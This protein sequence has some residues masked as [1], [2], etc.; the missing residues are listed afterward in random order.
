MKHSS[1]T[2]LGLAFLT[3][4]LAPACSTSTRIGALIPKHINSELVKGEVSVAGY[5]RTSNLAAKSET[6]GE[7]KLAAGVGATALAG[8]AADLA[9]DAVK[10][11]LDREAKKYE[12]QSTARCILSLEDIGEAGYFVFARCT[13]RPGLKKKEN[14]E[15]DNIP[16]GTEAASIISSLR[17]NGTSQEDFMAVLG[18]DVGRLI[19][20]GKV[21][22]SVLVVNV[23]RVKNSGLAIYKISGARLWVAGVGAKV[24]YFHWN[25]FSYL[26]AL[27]LKTGH[28]AEVDL[29]MNIKAL[30]LDNLQNPKASSKSSWV[31]VEPSSTLI[32]GMKVNLNKPGNIY[33]AGSMAGSWVPIPSVAGEKGPIGFVEVTFSVTEKDPSNVKKH[34]TEASE[35]IEKNKDS[36]IEKLKAQFAD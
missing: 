14:I 17:P 19:P 2:L 26:G 8:F 6:G 28:E 24:V 7:K 9:I 31:Q 16:K 22:Q 35:Q 12:R 29:A 3:L 32:K 1:R 34:I 30:Q 27:L 15:N 23:E 13:D 4:L 11:E 18:G 25:P 36:W 10:K 5:V 21:P 33:E 20:K